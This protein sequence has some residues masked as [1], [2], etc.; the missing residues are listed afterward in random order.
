MGSEIVGL[1]EF[2]QR[3]QR[4]VDLT[5][6]IVAVLRRTCRPR[7]AKRDLQFG[8]FVCKMGPSSNMLDMGDWPILIFQKGTERIRGRG[9]KRVRW[10]FHDVQLVDLGDD[11]YGVAFEFVK[12]W[13]F[14]SDQ[15]LDPLTGEM[16]TRPST[17]PTSPSALCLL[18]LNTHW[19]VY[20]PKT[21]YPPS[22]QELA[23]T[24]EYL[25]RRVR[26]DAIAAEARKQPHGERRRRRED[27][28]KK[29]PPPTVDIVPLATA[30]E[31][32]AVIAKF[33]KIKSFTVRILSPNPSTY[34]SGKELYE[35]LDAQREAAAA[36]NAQLVY[37]GPELK[38]ELVREEAADLISNPNVALGING[39][40]E[41]GNKLAQ[42]KDAVSVRVPPDFEPGAPKEIAPDMYKA[43][44]RVTEFYKIADDGRQHAA[45]I[46]AKAKALYERASKW[47]I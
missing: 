23:A 47:F 36:S 2:G 3:W 8:N 26:D 6:D 31:L 17:Y 32:D 11:V 19:L 38:K 46:A 39:E 14:R 43:L 1:D 21:A 9:E 15:H 29:W 42:T 34:K 24:C 27:L 13:T 12:D 22:M 16:V 41:D 44:E 7:M 10:L 25:L 35:I 18:V 20:Y 5:L 33:K 30:D 37:K 40:D 28:E 45:E 4:A